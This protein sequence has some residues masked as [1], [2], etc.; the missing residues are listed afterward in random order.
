MYRANRRPALIALVAMTVGF[1]GAVARADAPKEVAQGSGATITIATVNN[2]QMIDMEHLTPEFTKET[3]IKVNYVTLP[4]NGVREKITSDVATG[5]GQFD[6]ATVGT[7]EVPIWAKNKWIVDLKPSFDKMSPSDAKAYDIG[8][9]LPQV[10][11]ALT[12]QNDLYAVPFYGESSMTFYNKRTFAA[13]HLTMPLH[14]TWAQI[15]KFADKLTDKNANKYGIVL[16]GLPGWGEMG[17]PLTTV[18]NTYGGSWFDLNW[19]PQLTAPATMKAVN[20]YIDLLRR[21][22]P[23]GSQSN[24]FTECETIFSQNRGAMWVDATSAAGL[25]TD[26]KNSKV[27]SDVG[28]AFA[29]TD[30]TPKGSHWLWAWSLAIESSSKQKDAAFRFLQWST[31]KKYIALVAKTRGWANVPP[32]TRMSTF[33]AAGYKQAAPYG[34]IILNSIQTADPTDSTLHKVPYVGV[35]YVGI[36]EFQGIGTRVTQDLAA[37]LNGSQSVDAALTLAQQQT[38]RTMRDAGYLK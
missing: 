9:L 2:P 1:A 16:R 8:D 34:S 25:I 19:N 23:P 13:A 3:G 35:Q 20:F 18:I 32:G 15:S 27:A 21:D 5:G 33:A 30:V 38:E 37:T 29:P 22:G 10:K 17:A 28:Y 14:P 11:K 4:E 7:Y 6:L 12:Y 36:P 26:P 24:G 31:S